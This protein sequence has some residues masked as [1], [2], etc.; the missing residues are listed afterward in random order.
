M[1][2]FSKEIEGETVDNIE[3]IGGVVRTPKV[4]NLLKDYYQ[5]DIGMHINGDDGPALGASYIA[6]NYTAGV[7]VKKMTFNDGPNYEVKY[8]I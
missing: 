6:A 5:K 7:K 3:I 1:D 8:Y 4:Q 2:D